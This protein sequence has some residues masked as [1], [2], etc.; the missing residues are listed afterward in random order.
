MAAFLFSL[1]FIKKYATIKYV[2][3]IRPPQMDSV[4]IKC[5]YRIINRTIRKVDN[6]FDEPLNKEMQLFKE[7]YVH[8]ITRNPQQSLFD[9]RRPLIEEVAFALDFCDALY[10]YQR[11]MDVDAEDP[12]PLSEKECRIL[13]KGAEVY[14]EH[15]VPENISN[16]EIIKNSAKRHLPEFRIQYILA[17]YLEDANFIIKQRKCYQKAQRNKQPIAKD[18]EKYALHFYE[19]I[20]GDQELKR[21]GVC[22]E[23]LELYKI[24]LKIVDCLPKEKYNR[25]EKFK[26]KSRLWRCVAKS[27]SILDKTNTAAIENAYMEA[28]RYERAIENALNY[29]TNCKVVTALRRKKE[30]DEWTYR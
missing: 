29:A 3:K 6:H 22:T 8:Y 21:I 1:H 7:R 18:Y 20:T 28:T 27:L 2:N 15:L 17:D 19:R 16:L 23:K 11:V 24:T 12:P 26:L 4:D 25:T 30:N 13:L 9:E 5:L 10:T 14:Y